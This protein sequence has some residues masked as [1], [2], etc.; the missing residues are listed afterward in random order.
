MEQQPQLSVEERGALLDG[1]IAGYAQR[2]YVIA[3]RTPTTAQLVRRKKWSLFWSVVWFL[4]FVI[5][6]F[7][8]LFYYLAKRD[9]SVY[10]IVDTL[11]N[12][13]ANRYAPFLL[14]RF[15][16]AS[17]VVLAVPVI[18]IVLLANLGTIRNTAGG[19]AATPQLPPP[20]QTGSSRT[21]TI[22]QE[23][24]ASSPSGDTTAA[25]VP[26]YVIERSC[27]HR[28][29][30]GNGFYYSPTKPKDFFCVHPAGS[31]PVPIPGGGTQIPP[32]CSVT[33]DQ[34]IYCIETGDLTAADL[35]QPYE[36]GYLPT[37]V[38][39]PE[40]Y[41]KGKSVGR[42][43]KLK[44]AVQDYYRAVDRDDW[45]YTYDHLDDQ[46]RQLFTKEEW[47]RKNQWIA[48]NGHQGLSSLNVNA[49]L[50][51]IGN[52]A[53]VTVDRNFKD[54]FSSTLSTYF[55]Y[56]NGSWKHRFSEE[57]INSFV[58]GTPFKDFVST[59]QGGS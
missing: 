22:S 23:A 8:Y 7:L 25:M 46:T 21:G 52:T 33:P 53:N 36:Q 55:V 1:E 4:F 16:V 37:P 9:Q 18:A 6:F 45:T 27:V 39:Q 51:S 15:L 47:K 35:K 3:S 48:D 57:E 19:K 5:P 30:G 59:R 50:P 20:T 41:G 56:E 2:G 10:L 40:K 17:L 14:G 58:P 28:D 11:G 31:S 38:P 12:I 24:V 49:N 43:A 54:G 32:T 13:K 26:G 29:Y 44:Q 34:A 42:E